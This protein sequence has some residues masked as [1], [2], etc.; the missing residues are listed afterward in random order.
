[1]N[2]VPQSGQASSA[3]SPTSSPTC[4]D[5]QAL[6]DRLQAEVGGGSGGASPALPAQAPQRWSSR[7]LPST[8]SVRWTDASFWQRWQVME[9]ATPG[10]ESSVRSPGPDGPSAINALILFDVFDLVAE[11]GRRL[12]VLGGHGPLQLVTELDQGGLLLA[13]AGARSGTLPEWRVS[14]WMFSSSGI[15]S[16]RNTS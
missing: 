13:V 9:R 15:S 16:S 10:P 8:V 11:P 2:C 14:P 5:D 7:R 3:S 6:H 12:V 1:M 4:C